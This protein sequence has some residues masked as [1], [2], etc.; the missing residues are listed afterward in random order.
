MYVPFK[1]FLEQFLKDTAV[2]FAKLLRN[3]AI[4]NSKSNIS[5]Q[6]K[7]TT[8]YEISTNN[9]Y[10]INLKWKNLPYSTKMLHSFCI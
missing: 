1:S 6:H 4:K 2:F 7:E 3:A 10:F 9:L 5:K 8:R